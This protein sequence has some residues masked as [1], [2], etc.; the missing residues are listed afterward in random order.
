MNRR[1]LP[2]RTSL[3]TAAGLTLL[4]AIS[5]AISPTVHAAQV[6]VQRVQ[7]SAFD[8][9]TPSAQRALEKRIRTAIDAVCVLPNRELPRS[10]AVAAGIDACRAAAMRSVRQQLTDL[11]VRPGVRAAQSL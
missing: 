2:G 11:G 5:L 3:F 8:F 1:T 6:A 4:A 10:L 7:V 9:A